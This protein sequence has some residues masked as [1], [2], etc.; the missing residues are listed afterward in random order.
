[1]ELIYKEMSPDYN[2][3]QVSDP[4]LGPTCCYKKGIRKVVE[5]VKNDP[6]GYIVFTGDAT[7]AILPN[8]KRYAHSTMD[9]EEWLMTPQQQ[10]DKVIEL[11]EPVKSKIAI[12]MLG[13]HEYNSINTFDIC[14]YICK[15]LGGI[16]WGGVTSKFIALSKKKTQKVMHKFFFAHGRGSLPW[17]AKDPIQKK[18]NRL[19]SMKQKLTVTGHTD[20]IYMGI[21][22]FHPDQFLIINPTVDNE[23]MLTDRNSKIIQERRYTT[24]QN[25]KYIPPECRWYA[26]SNGFL[27][28]LAKPG[29]RTISYSEIA[30]FSPTRLGWLELKIRDGLLVD[31]VGVDAL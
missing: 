30:G 31:V 2:L 16:P 7:D 5:E 22:H 28:T 25:V 19:A 9:K 11:F 4:H 17:Q 20:C 1:M 23:V 24:K 27:R 13:N 29:T 18:A 21:S 26:C 10:A 12:W 14:D 15:G 3:R 6:K 8:D